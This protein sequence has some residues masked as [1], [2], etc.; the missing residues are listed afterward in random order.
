M[1][2]LIWVKMFAIKLSTD[3]TRGLIV[4]VKELHELYF[5]FSAVKRRIPALLQNE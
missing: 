3:D 1:A 4:I 5:C 2:G